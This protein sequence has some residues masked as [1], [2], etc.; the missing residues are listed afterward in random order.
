MV[1]TRKQLVAVVRWPSVGAC[2]VGACVAMMLSGWYQLRRI[3]RSPRRPSQP[4][5]RSFPLRPWAL[6]SCRP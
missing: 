3:G 1:T 4:Q 5:W 2:R 6:S